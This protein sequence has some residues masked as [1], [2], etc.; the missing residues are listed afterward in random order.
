MIYIIKL[1]YSMQRGIHGV[2]GNKR[3]LYRVSL[4]IPFP[5]KEINRRW[6]NTNSMVYVNRIDNMV[7]S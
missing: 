6:K 7:F 4:N 1:Q 5:R 3:V 2:W